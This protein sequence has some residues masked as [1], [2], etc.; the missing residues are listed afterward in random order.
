MSI[1]REVYFDNKTG[2]YVARVGRI[3]IYENRECNKYYYVGKEYT[4]RKRA[5]QELKEYL[6]PAE[7]KEKERVV[8][9]NRNFNL[10]KDILKK[11][12]LIAVKKNKFQYQILEDLIS[13]CY[14][15]EINS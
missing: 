5:E 10:R 6:L 14:I 9:Y 12:S 13:R 3:Y 7:R 1:I 15:E 8:R 4:S 11:L 2:Y